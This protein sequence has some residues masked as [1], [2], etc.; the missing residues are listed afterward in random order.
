MCDHCG[1]RAFPS[2][3]ELTAE[4]ET[5]LALAWELTESASENSPAGPALLA[6]LTV[7]AAKEER[8]LYPM[9]RAAG[10]LADEDSDT[11]EAEHRDTA[12]VV[13]TG[14]LD[15]ANYYALAAHVEQ[16]EMELFPAAMLAFDE[17]TWVELGEAHRKAVAG[18]LPA[19]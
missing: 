18:S 2:I 9:L 11:L 6:L 16:E 13:A 10:R 19:A 17:E 3:A 7:H 8:G 12:A 1:C 14:S 4:H 5:I 15:R